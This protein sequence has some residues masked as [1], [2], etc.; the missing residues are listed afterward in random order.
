ME[1]FLILLAKKA[2][3]DRFLPF[4]DE[5]RITSRP[6][7]LHTKEE[8]QVLASHLTNLEAYPMLKK[9]ILNTR[10]EMHQHNAA[11][12]HPNII[13]YE[14]KYSYVDNFILD[15]KYSKRWYLFHGSPIQNWYSILHNGIKN[16]SG[17]AL[18]SNGAVRG[19]GVYL[20]NNIITAYG[21]SG[22]N[23][24]CIAVVE[25]LV[26]PEQFYKDSGVYVVPDDKLLFPRYL[27]IV[28]NN[29]SNKINEILPYY[30]KLRESLLVIKPAAKRINN[31]LKSIQMY[32]LEN[33]NNMYIL[34]INSIMIRMYLRNFPY[35]P[36]IFQLAYKIKIH[37]TKV[38]ATTEAVPKVHEVEATTEAVPEAKFEY[39]NMTDM[40]FDERGIY[41]YNFDNW[42]PKE[43][44]LS[45]IKEIEKNT[46]SR[47]GQIESVEITDIEYE[48]LC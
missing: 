46:T 33:I 41:K 28:K 37:G 9:H 36:P 19:P 4:P 2:T 34:I 24:H 26:D 47:H 22:V 32:M 20:T 40:Y 38:Y 8:Y 45:T 17:T 43:T 1:E 6:N 16:M 48:I 13:E 12:I 25:L 39:S 27:Y 42:T 11:S 21:Y 31:E 10:L 23:T 5:Y 44:L 35:N 7:E 30:K 14:F 29:P 3:W 15:Q 18:M